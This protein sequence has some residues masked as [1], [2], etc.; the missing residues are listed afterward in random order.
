[1]LDNLRIIRADVVKNTHML[2]P[3][4]RSNAA[5]Y[6]WQAASDPRRA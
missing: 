3:L 2:S 4:T 6:S 5:T 1:L